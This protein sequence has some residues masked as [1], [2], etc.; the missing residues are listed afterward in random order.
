MYQ[1]LRRLQFH[2]Y[3]FSVGDGFIETEAGNVIPGATI[4][5]LSKLGI[6]PGLFGSGNCSQLN[7]QTTMKSKYFDSDWTIQRIKPSV[8]AMLFQ[9][10]SGYRE[11]EKQ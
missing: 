10:L 6:S 4:E 11:L 8:Y 7:S 3:Y 2:C 5:E 9:S 1:L